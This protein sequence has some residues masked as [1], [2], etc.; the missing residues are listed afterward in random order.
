M[1]VV[2][3]V[4]SANALSPMV[5]TELGMLID[6]RPVQPANVASPISVTES[7][8]VIDSRLV[9]PANA[10]ELISVTE[11]GI[12]QCVRFSSKIR[13]LKFTNIVI[14]FTHTYC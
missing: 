6:V 12:S 5:L 3:L 2:R 1:I 14:N 13:F 4:Q 10:R 8:R 7:G 11:S 9:Q